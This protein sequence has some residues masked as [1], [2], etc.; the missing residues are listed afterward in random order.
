MQLSSQIFIFYHDL[1]PSYSASNRDTMGLQP[2][3]LDLQCNQPKRHFVTIFGYTPGSNV[4]HPFLESEVGSALGGGG[5]LNS[6]NPA[7]GRTEGSTIA[8][9]Q[10]SRGTKPTSTYS[11]GTVGRPLDSA[12]ELS[13]KNATCRLPDRQYLPEVRPATQTFAL[14]GYHKKTPPMYGHWKS[15]ASI[16]SFP[17]RGSTQSQSRFRGGTCACNRTNRAGVKHT[18][19]A[20]VDICW[21]TGI[22][23]SGV[24]F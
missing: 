13:S 9:K 16:A 22:H 7:G 1:N 3:D 8:K 12:R 15:Q 5:T 2:F 18:K 6:S 21:N 14:A 24:A 19:A 11:K 10:Y 4:M 20:N 23:L 17:P